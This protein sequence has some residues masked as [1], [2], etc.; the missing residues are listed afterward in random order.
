MAVLGWVMGLAVLWIACAWCAAVVIG[1]VIVRAGAA[2]QVM[3][4]P[5]VG[6][7]VPRP[8]SARRRREPNVGCTRTV[9]TARR[10]PA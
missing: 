4:N 9:R 7:R 6:H 5:S 10:G 8:R 3:E 1:G 2:Q